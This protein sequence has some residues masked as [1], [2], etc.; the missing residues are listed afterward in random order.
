MTDTTL[1]HQPLAETLVEHPYIE[2]F[3]TSFGLIIKPDSNS[4]QHYL[5]NLNPDTLEDLGIG[6]KQLRQSLDSILEGMLALSD[7]MDKVETL[8][9]FGGVDKSGQAEN[10]ELTLKPGEV[11]C[12]VGPT[13]RCPNHEHD[14]RPRLVRNDRVDA[15]CACSDQCRRKLAWT[16]ENLDPQRRSLSEWNVRE[17]HRD[18]SDR[19]VVLFRVRAPGGG[20]FDSLRRDARSSSLAGLT[21]RPGEMPGGFRRH[22]RSSCRG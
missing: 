12:I 5:D 16:D 8:T 15:R 18:T 14:T 21:Q 2:D 17:F 4:L 6:S 3:M 9:I 10:H 11:I 13:C 20:S 1:F 7:P 19:A 22:H